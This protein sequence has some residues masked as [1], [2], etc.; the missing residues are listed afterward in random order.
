[1]ACSNCN[2]KQMQDINYVRTLAKALSLLEQN[3]VVIF[4]QYKT[5]FGDVYNYEVE[6]SSNRQMAVEI[7]TFEVK[8]IEPIKDVQL[9]QPESGDILQDNGLAGLQSST[10]DS[11]KTKPKRTRNIRK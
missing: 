9:Q 11:Y 1:M 3:N 8:K 6:T 5:G 7:I 2:N 4:K 10:G